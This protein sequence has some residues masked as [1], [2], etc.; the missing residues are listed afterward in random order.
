MVTKGKRGEGYI[1]SLGLTYIH[2]LCKKDKQQGS[3]IQLCITLN[4]NQYLVMTCDGK[5]MK[6]NIY[7]YIYT[8]THIYVYIC[9]YLIDSLCCTLETNTLL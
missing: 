7:I 5:N 3:T 6:K 2:K 9:V 8:H 1:K 4:H